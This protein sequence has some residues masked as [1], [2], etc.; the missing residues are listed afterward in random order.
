M[1]LFVSLAVL[2]LQLHHG[3]CWGNLGHRTAAVL[4]EKYLNVDGMAYVQS[5][6]GL[7]NIS[8]AS[9]WADI[10]KNTPNGKFT[11]SWHFVD[12]QDD[13]PDSCNVCVSRDCLPSRVCILT[14][15]SN[16][17]RIVYGFNPPF[18]LTT[19]DTNTAG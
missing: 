18:A 6:I 4:A 10:Y 5:L 3:S 13:P 11:A 14:A 19:A 8:D 12:A 9:V 17:V 7:E 16:M 1:L 2:A 15:I